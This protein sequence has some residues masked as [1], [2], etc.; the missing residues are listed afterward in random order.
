MPRTLALVAPAAAVLATAPVARAAAQQVVT[1]QPADTTTPVARRARAVAELLLAGDRARLDAYL[2]EGATA[3][4][5]ADAAF[6]RD[7]AALLDLAGRGA[8]DIV[9]I[10]GLG[11]ARIG[12]ALGEASG[13]PPVRAIIVGMEAQA[14]YRVRALSM[15][16]IGGAG[17]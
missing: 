9:R 10:D 5:L 16:R 4:Y 7:L 6:T 3:D 13:S 8:R 15:A 17:A 14:P 12:V 11:D 2:K 1:P